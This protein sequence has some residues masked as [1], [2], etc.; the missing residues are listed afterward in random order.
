MLLT[1]LIKPPHLK[2]LGDVEWWVLVT[3]RNLIKDENANWAITIKCPSRYR[4][5]VVKQID[6]HIASCIL[7]H[8]IEEKLSAMHAG[9]CTAGNK[10]WWVCGEPYTD[11]PTALIAAIDSLIESEKDE[12]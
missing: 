1:D 12:A 9:P 7:E 11:K 6:S 3:Q 10:E 8:A 4:E 5:V 2:F